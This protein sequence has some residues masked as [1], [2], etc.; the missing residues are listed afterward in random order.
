MGQSLQEQ[1]GEPSEGRIELPRGP[2]IPLPDRHPKN[3]NTGANLSTGIRN[4]TTAKAAT[5]RCPP[6][7]EQIH[8]TWFS[9]TTEDSTALRRNKILTTRGNLEDGM[10]GERSR[11][12]GHLLYDSIYIN[13]PEQAGPQSGWGVLEGNGQ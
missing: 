11:H 8:K 12:E 7:D 1:C 10:L 5:A 9:Q 6:A 4:S 13:C 3:C 2:A